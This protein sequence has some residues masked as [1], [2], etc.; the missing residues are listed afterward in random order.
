MKSIHEFSS[1]YLHRLPVDG[2]KQINGLASIVE[3][4]M[5]LSPFDEGLFVF[6]NRRRRVIKLLY[7]DRT[8]FA[9]WMKRLEE[10][11]FRWPLK[12]KDDTVKLTS[13]Q[14]AWLLDGIDI[15]RMKPHETLSYASVS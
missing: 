2:R 7:W 8:G 1:V 3:H 5:E 4:E 13:K 15:T 11:K 12:L 9:M 14:L 10:D 6:T